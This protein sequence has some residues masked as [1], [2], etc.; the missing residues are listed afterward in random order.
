MAAHGTQQESS[1]GAGAQDPARLAAYQS[2]TQTPLDIFSLAT[3]WIVVVPVGDFATGHHIRQAATAVRVVVSVVFALDM[4][5]RSL[6][7]PRHLRYAVTH[8][9]GVVSIAVPP[10]R[11][12]FSL[13]L[14]R[15]VFHRGRLPRFLLAEAILIL[16]GAV[17]EFFYE[18]H[19]PGANIHSLG[20]SLWWAVVTVTTVGYGDFYPVTVQGR[21]V[22]GLIMATGL[23]TLAVVTAQV[24]SSFATQASA[25]ATPPSAA[26]GVTPA[27]AL[28]DLDRRLARIEAALDA[29]RLS[30][31]PAGDPPG[32]APAT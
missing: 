4:A 32:G 11:V 31:G 27:L 12:F 26:A 7:A 19:A 10:V 17:I 28:E 8:P 6:L 2:R 14:M 18:R 16:N 22:A 21:V 1:A 13:R 3:L 9:L 30:P 5:V 20:D 15:S 24:A 23:I 29:L 25:G